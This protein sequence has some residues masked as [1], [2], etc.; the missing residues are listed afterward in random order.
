MLTVKFQTT[1]AYSKE[2]VKV[3][4][5]NKRIKFVEV[6]EADATLPENLI[7]PGRPLTEKELV[8]IALE[9]E[10]ETSIPFETSVKRIKKHI[11]NFNLKQK[12]G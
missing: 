2:I 6:E 10:A 4:K 5:E 11:A 1:K 8:K 9:A 12:H 7:K 3:L